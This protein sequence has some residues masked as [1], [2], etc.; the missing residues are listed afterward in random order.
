MGSEN[1][2]RAR[3]PEELKKDFLEAATSHGW[4]ESSAIQYLVRQF[5]DREK[6]LKRRNEETMEA[7]ADFEVG[8]VVDGDKVLKWIA[9]WGTSD[10]KAPP[11]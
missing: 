6:E 4:T 9:S 5:V 7:L 2:I 1:I 3:V 11:Q 10:E 8:L